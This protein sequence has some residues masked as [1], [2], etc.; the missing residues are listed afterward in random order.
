MFC[1]QSTEANGIRTSF[2]AA[3]KIVQCYMILCYDVAGGHI[4]LHI[5]VFDV[6]GTPKENV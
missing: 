1:L 6:R 5:I 4:I 3:G 2:E